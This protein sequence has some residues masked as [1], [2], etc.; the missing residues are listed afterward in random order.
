MTSGLCHSMCFHYKHVKSGHHR[1][2]AGGPIVARD[3]MLAGF[4]A[5]WLKSTE[6]R[7]K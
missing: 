1:R 5:L 7:C 2:F 3:W 6:K 4:L